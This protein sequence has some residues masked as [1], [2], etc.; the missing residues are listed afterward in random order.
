MSLRA[1]LASGKPLLGDGAMGSFLQSRG[2][3]IE[4]CPEALNLSTPSAL[5]EVASVFL[6]AGAEILQTNTFGGSPLRLAANGLEERTEEINRVAAE[7]VRRFAGDGVF[8][9]GSCGPCGRTLLPFG[10]LEPDELR[11]GCRRQMVALAAAGVDAFSIETMM[12]VEESL[13]ALDAARTVAPDVVTMTTLTFT[14]T[15]DGFF[16]HFGTP[17]AEAVDRLAQAGADVVGSNCG[18]GTGTMIRIT[19]E[20]RAA[21]DLPILIRPNAGLPEILD[22]SPVWPETPEAFAQGILQVVAAGATV[23][24]GCCGTTPAHIRAVRAALDSR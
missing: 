21:T 11:T 2:H 12:D 14:E 1:R 19:A 7:T 24:G 9:T 18:T 3:A 13:V 22:G 8:V 15:P 4:P 23:V 20:I 17:L 10:D 6:E 5:E 16:T